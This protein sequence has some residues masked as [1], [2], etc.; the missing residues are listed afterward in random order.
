MTDTTPRYT[1]GEAARRV[2]RSIDT[3]RR[4]H[5]D[6]KLVPSHITSDG[7]R[8]YSP[9]DIAHGRELVAL[10]GGTAA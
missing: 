4:W 7:Q 1:T 5:A 9:A 8:L 10:T 3:L 2:G 6:G